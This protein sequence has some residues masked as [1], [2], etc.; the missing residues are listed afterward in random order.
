MQ[1]QH[2]LTAERA[3]LSA[4]RQF[5]P[6]LTVD[7]N[8]NGLFD[9]P[10]SDLAPYLESVVTDRNLAGSIPAEILLIEGAASAEMVV[11]LHGQYNGL[12]LS[13][14]FSPYNQ[15]SPLYGSQFVGVDARYEL[16]VETPLGTMWYPQFVGTVRTVSPSRSAGT[17]EIGFLD[18]AENMRKPIKFPK[19]AVANDDV[20]DLTASGQHFGLIGVVNHQSQ[21]TDSSWVIDH[22]LRHCDAS[23][24][25]WRPTYDH[26]FSGPFEK[27]QLWVSGSGSHLPTIGWSS[28]ANEPEFPSIEGTGLSMYER[29]NEPHPGSPEPLNRPFNFASISGVFGDFRCRSV[30]MLSIPVRGTHYVSFTIVLDG[31]NALSWRDPGELRFAQYIGGMTSFE[32]H[33]DNGDARINLQRVGHFGERLGP[34]SAV[35]TLL[36]IPDDGR[37][38]ARITLILNTDPGFSGITANIICDEFTTGV[39]TIYS[40]DWWPAGPLSVDEYQGYAELEPEVGYA[41]YCYVARPSGPSASMTDVGVNAGSPAGRVAVLDPGLQQLSHLPSRLGNDA[42]SIVTD[43]A[44]SEMGAVF[45]DENGVFRFWNYQTIL[46]KRDESVRSYT[47]DDFQGLTFTNSLD[48]VRNIW[49]LEAVKAV[50]RVGA[51]FKSGNADE[52]RVEPGTQTTFTLWD[53]AA[54]APIPADLFDVSGDTFLAGDLKPWLGQT[55]HGY[56]VT[57]LDGTHTDGADRWV[58]DDALEDSVRARAHLDSEGRVALLVV[59]N[60]PSPSRFA[61]STI[62]WTDDTETVEDSGSVTAQPTLVIGGTYVERLDNIVE[63]VQADESPVSISRFGARNLRVA[64]DWVQDSYSV[65]VAADVLMPPMLTPTPATDDIVTPGD[66]RVQLGDT[67]TV[68]DRYGFGSSMDLQIMGIRREFASSGVKDTLKVELVN[69]PPITDVPVVLISDPDGSFDPPA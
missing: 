62:K 50:A 4:E 5:R 65:A 44:S 3:I 36:P 20:T 52:F 49:S 23:P 28:R 33:L 12:S 59:N 7:W 16:G 21:M 27:T 57:F 15:L 6:R 2:G 42:W 67:V 39:H 38:T 55:R 22:C 61:S 24:T 9:H 51:V 45:W 34:P 32:A 64:G 14:M 37:S 17:V 13:S 35:S 58:E 10:L 1:T 43:V 54:V 46:G 18:Y 25:P 48:S 69:S 29:H 60:S 11:T 40:G 8:N 66:P 63:S 56:A 47:L 30:D 19:W 53:A 68:I 26:E 31:Q 41:D